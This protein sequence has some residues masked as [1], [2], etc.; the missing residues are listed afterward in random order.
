MNHLLS[1][2]GPA[3]TLPERAVASILVAEVMN[4]LD[5]GQPTLVAYTDGNAG[6]LREVP[7]TAL[8]VMI[9]EARAKLDQIEQLARD[10]ATKVTIP[11]FLKH[12][13][14]E[15][16]EYKAESMHEDFGPELT[17]QIRGISEQRKDGRIIFAVPEGQD[18]I[19]RLAAL[20]N[21][22]N[23]VRSQADAA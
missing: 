1:T 20:R 16:H 3:S 10:Y 12:F 4:D 2:T 11:L 8:A 6:D 21:Y 18:P 9:R 14:I 19:Q 15:L 13:D 17:A 7:V 23:D 22:V 5:D